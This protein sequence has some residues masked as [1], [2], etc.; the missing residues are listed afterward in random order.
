MGSA[1][2]I[3]FLIVVVGWLAMLAAVVFVTVRAVRRVFRAG[4]QWVHRAGMSGGVRRPEPGAVRAVAAATV[5]SPGW[6]VAQ[7]DRQRMWRSVSSA[8][9]AVRV[10]QRSGAPVGDMPSLT[11]QLRSA[12]S[13]VDA[14]LRASAR[15]RS[16]RNE[17]SAQLTHIEAAAADL[18]SAALHSLRMVA[19]PETDDVVSAARIEVEALAAGLRAARAMTRPGSV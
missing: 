8:E 10:A 5:A 2:E 16:L 7:R 14:V 13:G 12:A 11:R 6:W 1:L 17:T 3:A 15:D 19:G 9:H 18:Q 4:R